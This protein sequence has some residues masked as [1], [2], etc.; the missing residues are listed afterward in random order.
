MDLR[1]S[2][3]S[4]LFFDDDFRCFFSGLES[5]ERCLLDFFRCLDL[6]DFFLSSFRLDLRLFLRFFLA[7]SESDAESS[8]ELELDSDPESESDSEL[9]LKDR[10]RE[11]LLRDLLFFLLRLE[12]FLLFL[13]ESDLSRLRL[14]SF[15]RRDLES[16]RSRLR[17]VEWKGCVNNEVKIAI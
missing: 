8:S 4:S 12:S 5:P 9:R 14:E 13:R 16:E 3:F 7:E 11:R 6:L 1:F 2:D 15:L 10:D 17:S